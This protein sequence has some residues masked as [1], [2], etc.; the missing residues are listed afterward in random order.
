[1]GQ[2][3]AMT[4]TTSEESVSMLA[5]TAM[6]ASLAELERHQADVGGH[7]QAEA[8]HH[9]RVA[10]RKLRLYVRLFRSRI[11]RA[12]A[13]RLGRDLRWAFAGLGALRDL[14]VFARDIV[15]LADKPPASSRAF[16]ARVERLT[17][18]AQEHVTEIVTSERHRRACETLSQLVLELRDSTD[19]V[20]AS[21]WL[22][23]RLLRTH[24]R[25]RR[26]ARETGMEPA[27]LHALRRKL[28]RFR[29]TAQLDEASARKHP[30][31]AHKLRK[32]TSTLQDE[33]GTMND[34]RV[35][36]RL[37]GSAQVA[38]P[39]EQQLRT[40]LTATANALEPRVAAALRA[41]GKV[42]SPWK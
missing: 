16:A 26:A 30:T 39:L 14:Q 6:A 41:F 42:R 25:L 22:A 1:M 2:A 32:R 34:L 15:P 27:A 29:Y 17:R 4:M 19:A 37:L 10:L 33:L 8:V 31:R 24:K 11:G 40:R 9:A 12:R 36:R 35:S 21:R 7:N 3:D 28:K 23:R 13:E 18:A 5:A 38:K 20:P